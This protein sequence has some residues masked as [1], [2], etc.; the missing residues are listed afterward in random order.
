MESKS[1]KFNEIAPFSD[2]ETVKALDRIAAHPLLT[3]ILHFI[4]P[5]TDRREYEQFLRSLSG[6][7]EFQVRVMATVMQSLVDRS[8]TSV[9]YSGLEN[10]KGPKR[11]LLLGNHRDIVLDPAIIQL[12]FNGNDVPVTEIAVGDN[13]ISSRF[14]EDIIRSNRMIKV[15]RSGSRRDIYASSSLLSE[16]IRESIAGGRASV[17]L[18]QRSGRTKDGLDR[19]SISV[20]KMLDMS[21]S[22]DFI[23]NFDELSIQPVTV[24]YEIEPCDFLKARELYHSRRGPYVKREGEDL[25]SILT[26]L[27][28]D[29]GRVHFHFAEPL[30]RDELD[31][32]ETGNRNDSFQALAQLIDRKILANYRLW[33]NN[34]IACDWLSGTDRYAAHYTA[35]ESDAFRQYAETGL[36]RLLKEEPGL[37]RSELLEILLGIYGNPVKRLS[38]D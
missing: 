35:A 23:R 26:G 9:T 18:A 22:S 20:L 13:L 17:W 19:T 15:V 2:E 10:V 3:D 25:N 8:T 33:P 11:S 14:V 21:G 24:S 38:S 29:K 32:C 28:Q 16:Y 36:D 12:I 1:D 4:S 34:Y 6:V 37:D 30:T 27:L 31:I 7:E 5:G